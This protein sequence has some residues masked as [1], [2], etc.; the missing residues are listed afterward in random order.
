ML[1]GLYR[2][3]VLRRR[4]SQLSCKQRDNWLTVLKLSECG[5]CSHLMNESDT[6]LQAVMH[7]FSDC[8]PG[9]RGTRAADMGWHLCN[10]VGST[11]TQMAC[12]ACI[13]EPSGKEI[14]ESLASEPE[15]ILCSSQQVIP[16]KCS[17]KLTAC[18]LGRRQP[19][20]KLVQ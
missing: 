4:P 15:I 20:L 19:C 5:S 8:T 16:G 10:E 13:W 7:G 6:G 14:A 2:D 12:C 9:A 18:V 17:H 3:R 1:L 11:S